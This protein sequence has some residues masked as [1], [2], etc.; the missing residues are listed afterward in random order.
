VS[1]KTFHL[2][3]GL[4]LAWFAA[5]TRLDERTFSVESHPHR[6]VVLPLTPA[7][8]REAP[9]STAAEP[10]VELAA[11][12]WTG[13]VRATER[14]LAF[15][16]GSERGSRDSSPL[17]EFLTEFVD[18]LLRPSDGWHF[19]NPDTSAGITE[20]ARRPASLAFA[21]GIRFS[22]SF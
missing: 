19:F 4:A 11:A 18:P 6:P 5:T 14:P 22:R 2:V 21:G 15:A 3:C 13:Q 9:S 1:A 12:D 8:A 10:A 7:I 20:S 17:E 16:S